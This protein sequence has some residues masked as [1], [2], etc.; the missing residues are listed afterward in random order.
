MR[1]RT[2]Q[3][4]A[5]DP[6]LVPRGYLPYTRAEIT[7][8][9]L[10]VSSWTIDL[11]ATRRVL[12]MCSPGWGVIVLLDG[13]QILS[14]SLE[15]P[16]RDRSA[17]GSAAGIGTVSATGA[18]DLAIV[19]GELAW[20]VPTAP[21]DTQ[22]AAARDTRTGPAETVIKGYVSANVGTGRHANRRDPA[23]PDVREV[24]V[25][26]DLGRGADVEFSARFDPLLDLI[27][28][29]PGGLGVTCQQMDDQIVFD[30][31]EPRD[32]SGSA[33]FSFEMGNLRRARWSDGIP[34]LT[35]VVVGGDGEG[36]TRVFRERRDSAAANA[37]RMSVARF[38]DQRSANSNLEMD[39]A[40]DK[41]LADGRR[42]GIISA[43]L[44]DTARLAY[45]HHYRLG[46]RVT[47]V[48]DASGPT[49][50]TDVITS[51]KITAA[52]ESGQLDIIPAVGWT[53]GP[54]ETR[55]D[56]ELARLQ[57]AVSA[58]GRST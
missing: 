15:E 52:A 46:D 22:T 47:I 26:P 54:Y 42:S 23:A 9:W 33:V 48:P 49:A 39:Q 37:W 43:E 20:P 28:A 38:L 2:L 30:V 31:V 57:R 34:E 56:R 41:E 3:V 50:F 17:E 1:P 14:G 21:V 7:L 45:G 13:E 16:E 25:G 6:D 58:L 8:N 10:A 12:E 35:H 51:V 4:I 36:T 11:P 44:V 27:R 19:A 24:V 32:L 18:D 40:G 55:A 29:V 53:D 5:R